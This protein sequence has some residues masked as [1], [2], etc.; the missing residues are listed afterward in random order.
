M[1]STFVSLV[2]NI[3]KTDIYIVLWCRAECTVRTAAGSTIC[4]LEAI[5]KKQCPPKRNEGI[6]H[7]GKCPQKTNVNVQVT[8]HCSCRSNYDYEYGSRG[9]GETTLL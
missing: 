7:F 9:R 1:I 6:C 4:D 3:D 2:S 5:K 8:K